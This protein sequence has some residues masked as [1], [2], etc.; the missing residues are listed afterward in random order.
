MRG[1]SQGAA[2]EAPHA[3]RLSPSLNTA[4]RAAPVSEQ[5]VPALADAIWICFAGPATA[6]LYHVWAL[7]TVGDLATYAATAAVVSALFIPLGLTCGA[8]TNDRRTE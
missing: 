7:G 8:Y 1:S 3:V 4:F 2:A 5:L 6:A